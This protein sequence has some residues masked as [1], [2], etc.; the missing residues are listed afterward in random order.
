M[1]HRRPGIL[2]PL[3]H[4]LAAL[5]HDRPEAHLGQNQ[6]GEQAARA[7][8]DHHRALGQIGWRTGDEVVA[9]VRCD[10]DPPIIAQALQ[11]PRLVA[12]LHVQ[13]VDETDIGFLP[14][15]IAAPEDRETDQIRF[16]DAQPL[17][18]R[19]LERGFGMVERKSDFGE[20]QHVDP[21]Q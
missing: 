21:G 1:R 13:R 5:Q 16:A 15:V 14:R 12:H 2:G 10:R 19:C 7:G 20:A 4:R 3:A 18:D 17:Q 9:H 11:Q 6:A 8:T